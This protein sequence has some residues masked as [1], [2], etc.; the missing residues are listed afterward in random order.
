[1]KKEKG[2]MKSVKVWTSLLFT[3]SL[4]LFTSAANAAELPAGY[5]AVDYII[6]PRGA[7]VDTLYRPNQNSRVVM[8]VTVQGAGEYWFGCWDRN[9]NDGA[10]AFGNDGGGIYAGYG[11][12][13]GTFGSVV[14]NGRHS[15]ELDKNAV[16]VD[17]GQVHAFNAATF[18]LANNLYLF[19]QNRN[20]EIGIAGAQ[21]TI[22]CHGCAIY[23]NGTQVRD[24]VPC[25]SP[26][27][28]TGLYDQ[29]GQRFYALA[30]KLPSGYT[31]VEYIESTKGGCQFIDTGYTANGQTKVVFDAVIP[32][33]WE[34]N[35]RFGVLFGS[36]TMT[37][38]WVKAFALQMCDGNT[39]VDT[40][41]FAYNGWYRQ[42]GAKPFSFGERVTVTCDG[43]HVEWTG[44]KAA[45]VDFTSESLASSK[46][47]LYIF[48]DNSVA[49]D[50][51]KSKTGLNHSVMRLYSFKIYEGGTLKRDFVP[52]FRTE[53]ATV[54]LYDTV[55]GSF[56][57]NSGSGN[58]GVSDAVSPLGRE[59]ASG[60]YEITESLA[61]VAPRGESALKIAEG[62]TVTLNIAAG[63]M[64]TLRGGDAVG[65]IGAGAGIEVPANATLKVTGAGK[66]VAYGGKAADGADGAN[67]GNGSAN[68]ST[69][70][71]TS[72]AGG[73]GG[74]GGGEGK[75]ASD[76]IEASA[77]A[78]PTVEILEAINVL[79]N[80]GMDE[81]A[82]I[83]ATPSEIGLVVTAEYRDGRTA[84]F[85]MKK[86]ADGSAVELTA[87]K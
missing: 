21:T 38:W 60:T 67:G 47:T 51:A 44:S 66:L 31:A 16:K 55:E 24:F 6:A 33:R 85:L 4:L 10:F 76:G 49:D 83:T 22:V 62:A 19:A 12:Q 20:G 41:R 81:I 86:D 79:A 29:I 52:C 23:D 13:G 78:I 68:D 2:K 59:L 63:V 3:F 32:A 11:N 75:G 82:S 57:G 64:V 39:A 87:M 48:A 53:D 71:F 46:S 70:N 73:A 30:V 8:D 50:G 5:T 36:R 58:L 77:A 7:Y 56:C 17:G 26:S 43:Q 28:R 65:T 15:V 61:F 18:A 84:R 27:G 9:Y 80:T 14:A 37:D 42:D 35:D 25:T 72:G 54:G 45:S 34:Q 69:G 74:F 1:M 40:V